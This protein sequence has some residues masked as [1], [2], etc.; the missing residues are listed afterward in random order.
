MEAR[1]HLDV[2]AIRRSASV[3]K[4]L[5]KNVPLAQGT[6]PRRCRFGS[7]EDGNDELP[8]RIENRMGGHALLR[9]S[10][11]ATQRHHAEK[12]AVPGNDKKPDD[13]KINSDRNDE[14]GLRKR[15]P[16]EFAIAAAVSPDN[17]LA[18]VVYDYETLGRYPPV[19]PRTLAVWD[20]ATGKRLWVAYKGKDLDVDLLAFFPDSKRLLVRSNDALKEVDAATGKVRRTFQKD[21]AKVCSFAFSQD[22]RFLLVG[23]SEGWLRFLPSAGGRPIRTFRGGI[24]RVTPLILSPDGAQAFYGFQASEVDPSQLYLWD[25]ATGMNLHAFKPDDG[26][27]QNPVVFAPDGRSAFLLHGSTDGKTSDLAF[28]HCSLPDCKVIRKYPVEIAH[29]V[30]IKGTAQHAVYYSLPEKAAI[31]R[32]GK[33]LVYVSSDHLRMTLLDLG[34]GKQ[35]WSVAPELPTYGQIALSPDATLALTAVGGGDPG[36]SDGFL[37]AVSDVRLQLWDATKGKRLRVLSGKE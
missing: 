5:L 10:S 8:Y 31:T 33:H 30:P 7:R 12:Q 19:K 21:A 26:L 18:A 14:A 37:P 23:D 16:A 22:G 24:T 27:G 9:P 3:V 13:L 35:L 2:R 29:K 36:P 20:V 6:T 15:P 32:N 34:T 25:T 4:T 28:V 11:V 1:R 17:K